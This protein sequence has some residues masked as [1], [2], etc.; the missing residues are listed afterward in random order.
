MYEYTEVALKKQTELLIN[1]Q[2]MREELI[3]VI[4]TIIESSRS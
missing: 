2:H 1:L 3:N 4:S